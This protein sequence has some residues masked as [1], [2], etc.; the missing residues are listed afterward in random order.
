[1]SYEKEAKRLLFAALHGLVGAL[2]RVGA[3]IGHKVFSRLFRKAE[4]ASFF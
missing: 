3:S 1:L 4:D 2:A